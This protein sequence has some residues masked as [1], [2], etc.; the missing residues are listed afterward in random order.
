M[1]QDLEEVSRSSYRVVFQL[2]LVQVDDVGAHTVEE[3]LGMGYQ[4][5]DSFEPMKGSKV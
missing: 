1:R 5:Q 2:A 3:V 4:N